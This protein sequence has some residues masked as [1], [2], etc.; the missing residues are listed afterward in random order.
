MCSYTLSVRPSVSYTITR[1]HT[2]ICSCDIIYQIVACVSHIVVPLTHVCT[3][4]CRQSINSV[5]MSERID[6]LCEASF[7]IQPSGWQVTYKEFQ[8]RRVQFL[9]L[10]SRTCTCMVVCCL[11]RSG[12]MLFPIFLPRTSHGGFGSSFG[13]PSERPW[14][15]W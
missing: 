8:S 3:G 12:R 5:L 10:I 4:T 14:R 9:E 2:H 1:S 15:P 6:S 7:T 11:F 13:I